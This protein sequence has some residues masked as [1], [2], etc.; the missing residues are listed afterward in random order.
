MQLFDFPGDAFSA[1]LFLPLLL[2]LWLGGGSWGDHYVGQIIPQRETESVSCF[3]SALLCL[4]C[5]NIAVFAV[6]VAHLERSNHLSWQ[7]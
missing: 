6:A 7:L 5:N 1:I 2:I 3:Y 4:P